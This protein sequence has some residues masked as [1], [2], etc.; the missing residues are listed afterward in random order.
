MKKRTKAIIIG[1]LSI[2]VCLLLCHLCVNYLF[3]QLARMHGFK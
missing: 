1:V 2:M 3:P